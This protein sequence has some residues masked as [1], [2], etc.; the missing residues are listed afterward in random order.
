MEII[1][2]LSNFKFKNEF[3]QLILPV[4][5]MG[6]D[7]ATGLTY[8]WSTRTFKS[9]K[10]RS[11]LTKKVGEITILVIGELFAA[12]LQLPQVIMAGISLYIMFMEFMS[13]MENLKKMGVPIPGFISKVLNTVDLALKEEEVA[14]A[15]KKMNEMENEIR[16]LKYEKKTKTE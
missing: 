2:I 14:E 6:I 10:M 12:G 3:W 4:A 5:L 13:V 8:A 11:G 9:K 1:E 7:F 15:L 16:S